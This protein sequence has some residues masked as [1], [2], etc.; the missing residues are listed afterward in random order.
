M[1][2]LL[3]QKG[4]PILNCWRFIDGT[5]RAICIPTVNQENYYSGHKRKHCL[6]YQSVLCPDGIIANL[7]GLFH[8]RRHDAAMLLD[9]G[10]YDQL[11]Q[12]AVFPDKKYVIY[13]DS[14]CPIRQLLFRPFQG[15]NLSED[16]ESFNAAMSALRQSAE[17]G[18]AKVVNDFAFIDFK[19]NLKLLLKDVRSVYKTAVLL[20]N[21]HFYLYGSQVGRF[22]THNPPHLKN[23]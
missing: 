10:L 5:A 15:R 3:L 17:W 1:F 23:V 22:L 8:R 14:G 21:C 11:L 2:R 13:G 4:C 20:S 16:Q 12:T 7:L 18:F 9:S 19:K 6:K